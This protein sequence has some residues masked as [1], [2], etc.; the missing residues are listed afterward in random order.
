MKHEHDSPVQVLSMHAFTSLLLS[1]LA[2][3]PFNKL[4]GSETPKTQ[5]VEGFTHL[6]ITSDVFICY[7]PDGLFALAET[8]LW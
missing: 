7:L 6:R 1:R 4:F 3:A 2:K 5:Q 8:L